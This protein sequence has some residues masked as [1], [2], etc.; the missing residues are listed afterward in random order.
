MRVPPPALPFLHIAAAFLLGKIAPLPIA[1]PPLVRPVGFGLAVIGLLL[2]V[3]ALLEFDRTRR[4]AQ[5]EG[6][7]IRLVTTGVYRWTRHPVYLGYVAMLAGVT[8]FRGNFWGIALAPALVLTMNWLVIGPEESDLAE[9]CPEEFAAYR[10]RVR[11]W[12]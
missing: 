8:L 10:A 6:V 9:R 3:I 2:G 11:R 4:R 5:R 12:L 1:A 7:K